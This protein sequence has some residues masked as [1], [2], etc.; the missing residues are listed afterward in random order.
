MIPFARPDIS[1]SEAFAA[2]EVLL[3]GMLTGGSVVHVFEKKVAEISGADRVV[4][5]DSCT[6]A[7]EMALRILGI[8]DGDEVITTPLTYT[9]TADVIRNVGATIVLC[10]LKPGRFEMD[11]DK[12][13]ELVTSRTKAIIPVDYGGVPCDYPHISC[14]LSKVSSKFNPA[15]SLQDSIG[16]PAVIADAAHSFGAALNGDPVGTLADF[17]CFSFHALK[18]VTTGGE[19]GALAWVDFDGVDN[20]RI[21]RSL[22]LLGDHGQTGKNI[23]GTHG[24]EW[25]YDVELFGQ[26]HIM[27]DVDA[28]AGLAQIER[29]SEIYLKR[30]AITER[31]YARLPQNVVAGLLHFMSTQ[32]SALHL[33]PVRIPGA[34]EAQRDHVFARMLDAGICCNVH[35]KPL[36]L[37]TA[38]IRAGFNINDYPVSHATYKN[39]LTLP[40]H[41]HMTLE[42]VDFVCE[43]L[44]KAVKEL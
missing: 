7:L 29:L 18:S 27:T 13:G 34:T 9:A 38:Y 22:R 31:Y 30:V 41:T 12:M 14:V 21:E 15:N 3:S 39:L 8:G 20:E 28:A 32:K 43:T 11:Y 1:G 37:F 36:P 10:D 25:E 16:R 23:R 42:D 44:G 17:T 33:F 5:Y 4:C 19:G 35:Y 26:N 40:Y 2:K 6:A 24:R